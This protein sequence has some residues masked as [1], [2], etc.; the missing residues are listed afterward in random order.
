[1]KAC[2]FLFVQKMKDAV[3]EGGACDLP[4]PPRPNSKQGQAFRILF[5]QHV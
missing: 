2:P 4:L 3:G 5:K 1:M